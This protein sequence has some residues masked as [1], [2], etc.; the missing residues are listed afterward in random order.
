MK[1]HTNVTGDGKPIVFLHTGLQTGLL[2]FEFQRDYFSKS[3][4]VVSPDL[5]GHGQSITDNFLRTQL[6]IY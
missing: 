4:Q 3:Y 6:R 5:R 2:D 1:L